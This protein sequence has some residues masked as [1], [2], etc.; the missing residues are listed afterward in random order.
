VDIYI[1]VSSLNR[2]S[3]KQR[4][5]RKVKDKFIVNAALV[6][7]LLVPAVAVHAAPASLATS[8]AECAPGF[9]SGNTEFVYPTDEGGCRAY[10]VYS[11]SYRNLANEY[12]SIFNAWDGNQSDPRFPGWKVVY[13]LG[14]GI[15]E[16]VVLQQWRGDQL[17]EKDYGVRPMNGVHEFTVE[18]PL[19]S[20]F[21]R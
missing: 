19:P 18:Y 6:M 15:S 10:L 9:L 4:R 3:K 12:P 14:G 21:A 5:K 16:E 13:H 2:K 8:G 1:K 17:W 20:R 7:L 11:A